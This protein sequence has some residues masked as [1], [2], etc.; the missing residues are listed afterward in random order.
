MTEINSPST[1]PPDQPKPSQQPSPANQKAYA[2]DGQP[3]SAQA[4]YAL[5]CDPARSVCV[6]ACAGAGKTWMLIERIVQALQAGCAPDEILAITFTKKAAAEMR[7]RLLERLKSPELASLRQ[8]L[9]ASSGQVNLSTFHA[10]FA[11]LVQAAPLAVRQQLGLPLQYE[12]LEDEQQLLAPLQQKFYARVAQQ[13]RMDGDNPLGLWQDLVALAQQVGRHKLEEAL[14]Q[15]LSKRTE[16]ELADAQGRAEQS[17]EKA[18]AIYPAYAHA[19][20]ANTDKAWLM[21]SSLGHSQL[22]LAARCLGKYSGKK[23]Q[24]AAQQLELA[25]TNHDFSGACKA[26]LTQAQTPLKFSNKLSLEDAQLVAGAQ[27]YVLEILA[28]QHQHQCWLYQ[29]RMTRVARHWL[30]CLADLKRERGLVD[31][32]DLER[33]ATTLLSDWHMAARVQ[34]RLD[35]RVRH[36]LIDEFQDTNPLQWQALHAWLASYAGVTGGRERPSLFI[37]GDPKQSIYRF[38]RA[39]PRVFEAAQAF[40]REAFDASLISCDHTR[41]NSHAVLRVVNSA[42]TQ[43]AQANEYAAFRPHTTESPSSGAA[44]RLPLIERAVVSRAGEADSE[45]SPNPVAESESAAAQG[46]AQGWRDSLSQPKV[47][48]HSSPQEREAEQAASWIA[49]YIKGAQHAP[50]AKPSVMVLARTHSALGLMQ[51]ALQARGVAAAQQQRLMLADVPAVQD[52]LALLN[53]L[54]SGFNELDL[55]RALKSPLF[56]WRDEDLMAL[57]AHCLAANQAADAALGEPLVDQNNPP[58]PARRIY[59]WDCL[60]SVDAATAATLVR[61]QKLLM[62]RPPHDALQTIYE[63]GSVL[64]RYA[65]GVPQHMQASSASALQALLWAAL[66][67]EGGRF[68][69][70][71]AFVRAMRASAQTIKAPATA[72]T[73][74]DATGTAAYSVQ[75]LTVHGAKGLEADVVVLMDADASKRKA[76]T[77]GMLVDW[78]PEEPA[79]RRCIFLQSEVRPPRCVQSL[80]AADQ[81]AQQLEELNALYVACTRARDTL[82]LSGAQAATPNPRSS[83][84]LL[85]PFCDE[86]LPAQEV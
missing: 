12:L 34:E 1:V 64:Q 18:C 6:E 79:P 9:L 46:S 56:A 36:V 49:H 38:R 23:E 28:V 72:P 59:W 27:A 77:A 63:Q 32:P 68:L 62:Q 37:V 35:Q 69:S 11:Q 17:V 19:L 8:R 42:M 73:N 85:A 47:L 25:L 15:L 41:R 74:A 86:V 26:L 61:W 57:R 50:G 81:A 5:A 22:G 16:F 48:A 70:G 83:W 51:Q 40:L 82:V 7:Q 2:I 39:E 29:Q 45:D 65:Q 60:A 67:V 30:Q 54:L 33:C 71:Y 80:L 66:E 78:Q 20:Q 44:L 52:V 58:A 55:A 76:Q 24:Q 53:A 3:V 31:M 4:F 21:A 14:Q 75:L 84:R 43:L 10:W 13:R